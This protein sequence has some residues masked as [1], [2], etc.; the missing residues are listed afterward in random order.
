MPRQPRSKSS[1]GVYHVMVRGV[2]RQNIFCD[3]EDRQK[4]LYILKN[5]QATDPYRILGYCLMNNHVH[6]LLQEGDNNIAQVMKRI[7]VAYVRWFNKKYNRVGHLF[8]DRFKSEEV[9]E[10]AY[11]LTVLRYIHQNPIKAKLVI[12]IDAYQWT[13]YRAYIGEKTYPM[14]LV[15]TELIND[16]L[17]IS[18]KKSF[19]VFE[20]YM[21]EPNKDDCL[22][23]D[24]KQPLTDKELQKIIESL[25]NS[26]SPTSIK[27][28]EKA[29]RLEILK[30]IKSLEGVTVRQISRITGLGRYIIANA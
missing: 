22:E 16:L 26:S 10:E 12:S 2:N 18:D 7:G 28:M 20:Q 1:T 17:G 30:E 11:L 23:V 13:S 27:H 14:D 15:E 8:Q 9:E 21:Q 3:D 24:E 19:E 5:V 6:L 25:T 4:Y 29:Q